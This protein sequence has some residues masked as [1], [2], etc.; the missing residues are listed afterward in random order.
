MCLVS[1]PKLQNVVIHFHLKR[2]EEERD[3]V[4]I[5]LETLHGRAREKK[6]RRRADRQPAKTNFFI[7]RVGSVSFTVFTS[8]ANVIATG[9]RTKEN[10]DPAVQTFASLLRDVW[11]EKNISADLAFSPPVVVNSTYSGT[12]CCPDNVKSTCQLLYLWQQEAKKD[13][14][15]AQDNVSLNFRSQFF[16]SVRVRWSGSRGT[17]NVFNNGKFTLVGVRSDEEAKVAH[18]RICAIIAKCLTTTS[19]VTASA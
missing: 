4:Q 12:I 17:I 11:R 19:A 10:I 3:K 2:S 9:I 6:R 15:L 7:F 8:T 16:P 1:V 5:A 13:P 18:Q 14:Q